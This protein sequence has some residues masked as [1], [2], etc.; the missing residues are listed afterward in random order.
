MMEGEPH[1]VGKD[2]AERLGYKNPSKAINDHCRGLT[3]RYPSDGE[4]ARLILTRLAGA[5]S[6]QVTELPIDSVVRQTSGPAWQ[7]GSP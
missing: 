7:R 3:K 1:L 2:V 5:P 4:A 6:R